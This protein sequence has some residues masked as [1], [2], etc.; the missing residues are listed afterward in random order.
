MLLKA[1]SWLRLLSKKHELI[2]TTNA[3][4]VAQPESTA[5]KD[6]LI[7]T[8]ELAIAQKST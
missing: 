1:K 7:A 3:A 2:A 6:L 4:P 5:W 8:G